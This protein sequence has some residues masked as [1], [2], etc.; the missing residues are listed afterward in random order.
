M[1]CVN[2]KAGFPGYGDIFYQWRL[3]VD[4]AQGLEHRTVAPRVGGSNPLI[5]PRFSVSGILRSIRDAHRMYSSRPAVG[6]FDVL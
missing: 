4:V 1:I 6:I 2:K 5:H 3:L